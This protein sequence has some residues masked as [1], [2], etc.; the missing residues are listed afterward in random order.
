[1]NV[2]SSMVMIYVIADVDLR[3]VS[4]VGMTQAAVTLSIYPPF[5]YYWTWT[6]ESPCL[7]N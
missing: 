5:E 3:I 6:A 7:I 2:T 1:M 4:L